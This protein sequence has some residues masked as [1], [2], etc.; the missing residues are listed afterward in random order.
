MNL[1]EYQ[2]KSILQRYGVAIP[3][4]IVA[5]SPEEAVE[6]AKE[7]QKKQILTNGL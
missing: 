2:G 7:I 3:T 1:H 4:G 6:A 5:L